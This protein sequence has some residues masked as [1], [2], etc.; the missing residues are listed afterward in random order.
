MNRPPPIIVDDDLIR[1]D[2]DSDTVHS[3]YP[4]LPRSQTWSQTM[5]NRRLR[6]MMKQ[7]MKAY[8]MISKKYPLFTPPGVMANKRPPKTC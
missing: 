7:D 1:H 3:V 2:I 6:F 4:D 8:R 5:S